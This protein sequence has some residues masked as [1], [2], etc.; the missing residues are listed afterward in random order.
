VANTAAAGAERP[1]NLSRRSKKP[2]VFMEV[3]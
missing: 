1:D 2:T 3:F